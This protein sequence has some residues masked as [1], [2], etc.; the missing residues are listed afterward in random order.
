M[1][2]RPAVSPSLPH[3][4]TNTAFARI[5]AVEIHAALETLMLKSPIIFGSAKL[6]TVWSRRP[7]NVPKMTV[8]STTQRRLFDFALVSSTTLYTPKHAQTF[9]SSIPDIAPDRSGYRR[10]IGSS[11]A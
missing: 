7:R 2:L 8:A 9:H 4:G 1:R 10:R 5:Y 11:D 6:T 3:T